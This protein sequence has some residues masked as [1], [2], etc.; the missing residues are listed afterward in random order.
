V[1]SGGNGLLGG[2]GEMALRAV[3]GLL[4]GLSGCASAAPPVEV[5][6]A[7]RATDGE[8][9]S[10]LECPAPTR[11]TP[12]DSARVPRP[13]GALSPLPR[14]EPGEIVGR[15]KEAGP[16]SLVIETESGETVTLSDLGELEVFALGWVSL[17]R[18]H[19]LGIKSGE[20]R[21]APERGGANRPELA[22]GM[23]VRFRLGAHAAPVEQPSHDCCKGMNECKGQGNCKTDKHD[24]VGRNSCKGQG[25]CK[26]AA[27][28]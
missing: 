6:Q 9:R 8:P 14:P 26:P 10:P 13:P 4:S 27:C 23:P 20:L 17:G 15:I 3:A 28:E 18:A 2:S 21:V 5:S 24:C 25:G 7:T 19:V 11:E 16:S 12:A 22:A 1:R